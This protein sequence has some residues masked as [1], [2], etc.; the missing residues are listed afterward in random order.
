MNDV[1]KLIV[2]MF[3]NH[4][5]L[6][7]QSFLD[8]KK[9]FEGRVLFFE[10]RVISDFISRKIAVSTLMCHLHLHRMFADGN[11]TDETARFPTNCHY[12]WNSDD[13][14]TDEVLQKMIHMF[15]RM[16]SQRNAIIQISNKLRRQIPLMISR[17][18]IT[19]WTTDK[20]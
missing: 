1:K 5:I 4:E 7:Y 13:D 18:R 12:R 2:V 10:F 9:I 20:T 14:F 16:R 8:K 3:R 6:S 15:F 17:A 19:R 11:H